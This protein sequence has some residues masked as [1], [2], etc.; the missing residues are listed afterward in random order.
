M[1]S[2]M[3]LVVAFVVSQAA[4]T[5]KLVIQSNGF[6]DRYFA[7]R[8]ANAAAAQASPAEQLAL[9][10]IDATA[11]DCANPEEFLKASQALPESVQRGGQTIRIREIALALAQQVAKMPAGGHV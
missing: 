1:R 3:V 11:I 8:A 10:L 4:A 9:A 7:Q 5:A 6:L 2:P